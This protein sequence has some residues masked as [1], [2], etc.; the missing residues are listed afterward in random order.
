MGHPFTIVH[1]GNQ[2]NYKSCQTGVTIPLKL[3]EMKKL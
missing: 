1:L 2:L 3:M